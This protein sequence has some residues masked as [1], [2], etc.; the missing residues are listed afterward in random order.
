MHPRES[1]VANWYV[2][3]EHGLFTYFFLKAIQKK[4]LSDKN[5][6]G[7]LTL[8]EIHQFLSDMAE[9]VPYHSRK[10]FGSARE[11]NPMLLGG[12]KS[13]VLVDYEK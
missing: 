6:D 11:Q 12:D 3:Q 8:E 2:S 13:R 9:G 7:H 1:Q 4:E 5:K 10:M